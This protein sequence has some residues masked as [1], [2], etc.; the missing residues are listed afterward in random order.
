MVDAGPFRFWRSARPT[1]PF[2]V[3]CSKAESRQTKCAVP[4]D[5]RAMEVDD[6]ACHPADMERDYRFDLGAEWR[7]VG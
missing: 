3:A 4:G 1:V 5:S 7:V 2:S 6:A